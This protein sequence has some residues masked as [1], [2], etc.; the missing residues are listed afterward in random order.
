MTV[1][2]SSAN[3]LHAETVD[4]LIQLQ[5]VGFRVTKP[6]PVTI[7]HP[8]DLTIMTGSSVAIVGPSGAG[9]TTL[10]SII[11]ALQPPTSGSYRFA[12][13]EIVGLS[14]RELAHFRSEYLG[15]VFQNSH[16][17]DERTTLA[18]VDLGITDASIPIEI[19]ASRGIAALEQVGLRDLYARRAG[20]LSGGERHRAAIARALVKRPHVLIADEPTAALD[21]ATGQAILD[22]L[23]KST[24]DGVTLI[25]VTHDIRAA[26]MADCVVR[27]VDGC[28]ES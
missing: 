19:R 18:N 8:L 21:Q 2:N 17:I 10:A 7:L 23:K 13:R 25:V 11:G 16:L 3:S 1:Q 26:D 9:K 28:V 6:S 15:F 5:G 20:D 22:L 12:G 27:I 24:E 4:P 14:L